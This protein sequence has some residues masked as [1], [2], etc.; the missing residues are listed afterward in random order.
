MN[1]EGIYRKHSPG[2]YQ[3]LLSRP[4]PVSAPVLDSNAPIVLAS[5]RGQ[6]TDARFAELTRE[7]LSADPRYYQKMYVILH[8]LNDEYWQGN[9][10]TLP[11]NE[12]PNPVRAVTADDDQSEEVFRF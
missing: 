12:S 3:Y 5:N 10:E 9:L 4:R 6:M 8:V 11:E 1:W 7:L 2:V